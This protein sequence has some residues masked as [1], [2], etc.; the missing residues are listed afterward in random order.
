MLTAQTIP[1]IIQTGVIIPILKKPTLD[2]NKPEHYR[3]ITL[4]S[5]H[6]KLIEMVLMPTYKSHDDQYGFTEERG[7]SMAISL[8]N[9]LGAYLNDAGSPMYICTL[10]AERCFDCIWHDGLFY[11]LQHILPAHHWFYL[12]KWYRSSYATVRWSSSISPRF[13]ITRGMKQGSLLSPVLF[14]IFL[15]DLLHQLQET[16]HGVRISDLKLNC[17][18]YADDITVFASTITGLQTLMD[19][20]ISYADMWRMKFSKTKSKCMVMGKVI[21][22][23]ATSWHLYGQEMQ[24]S[25][26]IEILGVTMSSKS[27]PTSHVDKRTSLCRRSIYR[28]S[29]SGMCYPGLEAGAK[30]HIWN[31]IGAPTIQY[32]M[33]CVDLSKKNM[34]HL[35]K[36]QT[37]II[38]NVM[39]LSKRSHH[40]HLL[41]ALSI[42]SFDQYLDLSIRRL[43]NRLMVTDTPAGALQTRLLA[44]YTT[45]GHVIKHTLLA[46]LLSR[47]HDPYLL[48][49]HP[50]PRCETSLGSNGI[51][52]SLRYLVTHHNYIKPWSY[53]FL[54]VRLLLAAF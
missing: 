6:S 20:C 32:G 25:D 51:T 22:K 34:Q 2:A 44:R 52:D 47:L 30:A 3:P 41:Q 23:Y 10:D 21:T 17:C 1:D 19:T 24:P 14:K 43:Y 49:H 11:K 18:T 12:L 54:Q 37:N 15:D 31:T 5:V 39:G 4:S 40:T 48:I 26:E 42:P 16:Q 33:E 8:I 28:L 46:R 35:S 27:T 53:E 29:P 9:D 36:V 7:T 13:S 50:G 45:T 38:K